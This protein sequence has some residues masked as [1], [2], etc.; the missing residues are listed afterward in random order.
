MEYLLSLAFTLIDI[1]CMVF[2]LDAFATRRWTGVRFW[3]VL[4]TFV[5]LSFGGLFLNRLLFSGEQ[6][7]KIIIVFVTSFFLARILYQEIT[8]I[9]I[10]FLVTIE[11]LLNYALSMG[12]GMLV[13]TL[14]GIEGNEFG[15]AQVPFVIYSALYYSSELTIVLAFRKF[16]WVKPSSREASTLGISQLSLYFLY[17][18]SSFLMLIVLLYASSARPLS[19]GMIAV[20]CI[21]IFIAN[22]A[23]LFLLEQIE[24]AARTRE[25][26]L[27]LDQQL[28]I[29]IKNMEAASNLYAAQR[30]KVHDFR[31]HINVLDN[32]L[33]T[34]EYTAAE[35]YIVS[36][37]EFQSERLL[38]V[39]TH[40]PILDA[41]FNTKASFAESVGVEMDFEVNDLS[42]ISLDAADMV[43]LL[44][45]LIDNAIEACQKLN[46]KK[47]VQITAVANDTFFFTVRNTSA[48]VEIINDSIPTTKQEPEMHGF[49][50]ENV[51]LIL[52]KYSGDYAMS[53]KDGWFQFTGEIAFSRVS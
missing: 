27:A 40:H 11:Y 31:A 25:R 29:Q 49:G 48:P 51:K 16:S 3:G 26:L 39:N 50:L 19:D 1:L 46:G 36:V 4:L 52:K 34:H 7:T 38:L 22:I 28:Q 18:F 17:P 30:K 35:A 21:V 33:Q 53:Y 2:F 9:Y 41:L 8:S 37:K 42:K 13:S 12:M 23:V 10:F 15:Y 43:V 45:N 24:Q 6:S 44:S 32:L 14:Y 5:L 47:I 20:C